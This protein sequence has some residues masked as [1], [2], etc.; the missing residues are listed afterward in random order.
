MTSQMSARGRIRDEVYEAM[1]YAASEHGYVEPGEWDRRED[2]ATSRIIA[3]VR[4][5]MLSD[6]A[7]EAAEGAADEFPVGQD[8]TVVP[9]HNGRFAV[10]YALD[11]VFGE[12][13]GDDN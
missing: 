3:I 2:Q 8:N 12:E 1:D 10:M 4:E 7:V 13:A 9:M 5:A 11:A 6:A